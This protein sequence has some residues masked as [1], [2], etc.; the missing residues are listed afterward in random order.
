VLLSILES[1]EAAMTD[2]NAA[3]ALESLRRVRFA[4][5]ERLPVPW[6]WDAAFAICTGGIYAVHA[7]PSPF[8]P[9]FTAPFVV[10]VTWLTVLRRSRCGLWLHSVGPRQARGYAIALK[11]ILSALL[12]LTILAVMLYDWRWAPALA[13]LIAAASTFILSRLWVCA[14]QRAVI[15]A[16]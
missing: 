2:Q 12:L 4:I 5:A 9:L 13:G 10:G 6:A 3:E 7:L 8:G 14:Y 15:G 16:A 11:L 1:Q